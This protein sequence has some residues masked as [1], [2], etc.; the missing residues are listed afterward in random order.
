[1]TQ[2]LTDGLLGHLLSLSKAPKC[3]DGSFTYSLS[4]SFT[5]LIKALSRN[6]LL[7][8]EWS[9]ISASVQPAGPTPNHINLGRSPCSMPSSSITDIW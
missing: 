4:G 2:D 8:R 3:T 1:M 9:P 6:E 7:G 5:A